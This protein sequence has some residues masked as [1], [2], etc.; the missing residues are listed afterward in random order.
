MKQICFL[1]LCTGFFIS[2]GSDDNTINDDSMGM[3]DDDSIG[4]TDDD[5]TPVSSVIPC[6]NGMA[7][8]FP[9]DGFDL[10]GRVTLLEM[11][12]NSANDIWGWTDATTGNEYALVVAKITNYFLLWLKKT[13]IKLK[14]IQA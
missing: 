2:C 8:D 5:V 13:L 14:E 6:E 3:S 11:S 1:L 12:A 10:L 9:C 4:M 7:G